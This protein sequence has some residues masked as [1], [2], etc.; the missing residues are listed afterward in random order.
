M[1]GNVTNFKTFTKASGSL[2]KI[3]GAYVKQS[4][5][6]TKNNNMGQGSTFD[7]LHFVLVSEKFVC[8]IQIDLKGN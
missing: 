5:K 1:T 4:P 2:N 6:L 7:G 3:V 8:E